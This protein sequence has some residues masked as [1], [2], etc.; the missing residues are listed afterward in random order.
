LSARSADR[1]RVKNAGRWIREKWPLRDKNGGRRRKIKKSL[2]VKNK[3]PLDKKE[4]IRLPI[5]KK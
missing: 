3:N 1:E 4:K 5:N 2:A